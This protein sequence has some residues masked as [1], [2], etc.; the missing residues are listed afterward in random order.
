MTVATP[1]PQV[2]AFALGVG[3]KTIAPT[4]GGDSHSAM[5]ATLVDGRRVFVKYGADRATYAAEAHGLGW[6]AEA[7]AL[8]TPEVLSI[9]DEGSPFLAL[10]FVA[11]GE[12]PTDFDE[13]LGRGLAALHSFGAPS[14]GLAIANVM[15]RVPQDNRPLANWAAF[16]AERRLAPLVDRTRTSGALDPATARLVDQVIARMPELVGPDEPPAR[17]H[18]DLWSGNVMCDRSG[19]PTIV[20]PAVYG[21]HR[22]IDL[23]MLRLFGGPGPRCFAAYHEAFPV[24]EGAMRRVPLY[25]LYPLLIHVAMFGA[26]YAPS[27]RRAAAAVLT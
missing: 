25:Q 4:R 10:A 21:G 5:L 1:D 24:A 2:L 17:L 9:G 6:L 8:A 12:E 7:G 23:A 3:V 20:D 27:V 14:F 16:Y 13:R 19:A 22:E 11:A 18:G 15:G 26:G